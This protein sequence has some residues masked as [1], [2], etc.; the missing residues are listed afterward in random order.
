MESIN[1]YQVALWIH[2]FISV[3]FLVIAIWLSIRSTRGIMKGLPYKQLDKILA[4]LF[5]IDLYLQLLLG[6]ILFSN[7]SQSMGYDYQSADGS[8][9]MVS[10]RLWPIE[11]IVLMLFALFIANL[12]L[13]FSNKSTVDVT[14]HRKTLLYYSVSILL[15]ATSLASIYWF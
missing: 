9:A 10:K 14:K 6:F 5:I 4:Y 7:L 13:I 15:I 1:A 12:G 8:M 11:H 2:Y 3:S